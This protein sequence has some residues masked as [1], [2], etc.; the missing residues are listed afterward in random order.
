[1]T[2]S[3]YFDTFLQLCNHVRKQKHVKNK[4]DLKRLRLDF[5]EERLVTDGIARIEHAQ[6]MFD[7]NRPRAM[8]EAERATWVGYQIQLAWLVRS[9][10]KHKESSQVACVVQLR[11][12][13]GMTQC[14]FE[15]RRITMS[16][17]CHPSTH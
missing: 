15:T 4:E 6:E 3:Q 10:P 2:C 11:G 5:I 13:L 8:T 14:V 12:W 16:R 17:P 7:E 1:M 9:P